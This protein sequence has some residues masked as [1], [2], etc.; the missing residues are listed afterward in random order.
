[1]PSLGIRFQFAKFA[2]LRYGRPTVLVLSVLVSLTLFSV[3]APPAFASAPVT[4][5]L[6]TRS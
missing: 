1:M 6:L 5:T 4:S 3:L 2:P